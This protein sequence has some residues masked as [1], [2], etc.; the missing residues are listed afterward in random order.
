MMHD[1]DGEDGQRPP[2]WAN[3][4]AKRDEGQATGTPLTSPDPPVIPAENVPPGTIGLGG[5]G[6]DR[7]GADRQGADRQGADR[8]V[9]PGQSEPGG[10][11]WYAS[12]PTSRPDGPAGQSWY[13]N[14]PA[15]AEQGG[16]GPAGYW[17]NGTPGQGQA[18]GGGFGA[19]SGAG[20]GAGEYG[21]GYRGFAG[22]G[23]GGGPRRRRRWLIYGAVGVLAAAIGAGVTVALYS[24]GQAAAPS[25]S[26]ADV[27]GPHNNAAGSGTASAPLNRAAVE[28]RVAPGLVDITATLS[29]ASETAEGSGMILSANGLVL[30]NNHVIDGAT[31]VSVTLADPKSG[32][33]TYA[34][35]IL[36]YD[37]N[38]DVALLQ[39]VGASG[40]PTVTTGNSSQVRLGTRVL[41]LGNADGKGGATSTAGVINALDRTIQ[42]NDQA[43]DSTENLKHMLQT[44]AV[45]QQGDS[46]GALAND[47]GQ[48]IGMITAA[49]TSTSRQAGTSVGNAG[50]AIPINSALSI[51]QQIAAGTTSANVYIGTPGFLGVQLASSGSSNPAQQRT[52]QI[53]RGTA[54]STGRAC[55]NSGQT[56]TVPGR[57][58]PTGAGALVLGVLCQ[59]AASQ[60]GLVP[61]DVITSVD[62]QPVTTPTSLTQATSRDRATDVV[63]ITW[64]GLDGTQHS[65]SIEMGYG[66][67]R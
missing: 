52:D 56:T 41:A 64:T 51:A 44:N 49:N 4:G 40:L 43:S 34:A 59:T 47:A 54:E 21:D 25:I 9:N 17:G 24:H 32:A 6:T 20:F 29:Y 11:V 62:G 3:S 42:A 2:W 57:I 66:P 1:S 67:A 60:L 22:E 46:G 16:S 65:K 30:T 45:I 8:Q 23:S 61:G 53:A 28:K 37:V 19:G 33:Q 35:R 50:F 55:E 39:L 38:D 15:A 14:Q 58:A 48:V 7:Q 31:Q 5:Q 13:S 27:P 10:Q 63:T 26:S 36:G 18:G 12:E